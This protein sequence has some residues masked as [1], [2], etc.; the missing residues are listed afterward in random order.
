MSVTSEIAFLHGE[1]SFEKETYHVE[2]DAKEDQRKTDFSDEMEGE[3]VKTVSILLMRF[4]AFFFKV[5]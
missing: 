5:V 1:E 2:R 4:F 3:T